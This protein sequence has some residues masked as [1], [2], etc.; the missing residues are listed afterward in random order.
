SE[1]WQSFS[2]TIPQAVQYKQNQVYSKTNPEIPNLETAIRDRTTVTQVENGNATATVP[3]TLRGQIVGVFNLKSARNEWAEDELSIIEVVAGQT[4]LALENARLIE[5][6]QH[7]AR[8]EQ[9]I[10]QIAT[11]IRRSVNIETILKTTL[12]ELSMALGVQ[13]ATIQ[14]GQHTNPK[15]QNP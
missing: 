2:K 5:Q 6:T 1:G 10:N 15:N 7:I 11:K 8:R 4:A 3:L 13:E 14:F 12:S 9:Q